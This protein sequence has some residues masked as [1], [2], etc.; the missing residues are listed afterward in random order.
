MQEE[1]KKEIELLEKLLKRE[2]PVREMVKKIIEGWRDGEYLGV[3]NPDKDEWRF[4][5]DHLAKL[6]ISLLEKYLVELEQKGV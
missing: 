5:N 4:M 1:G 2:E 3:Y 6:M